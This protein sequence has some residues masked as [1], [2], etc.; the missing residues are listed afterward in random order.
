MLS[1]TSGFSNKQQIQMLYA[2]GSYCPRELYDEMQVKAQKGESVKFLKSNTHLEKLIDLQKHRFQN[3]ISPKVFLFNMIKEMSTFIEEQLK[4][5]K[6]VFNF[7]FMPPGHFTGVRVE[8][9]NNTLH[10]FHSDCLSHTPYDIC[11][12]LIKVMDLVNKDLNLSL[13]F[14][15]SVLNEDRQL[16][17]GFDCAIF[18][19]RD[20]IILE[21]ENISVTKLP[22]KEKIEEICSDLLINQIPLNAMS[23]KFLKTSQMGHS[24][25][26]MTVS[27]DLEEPQTSGSGWSIQVIEPKI[28]RT[29]KVNAY[30]YYLNIKYLAGL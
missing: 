1:S 2:P 24:Q 25:K 3:P 13:E 23:K 4:Q 30:T 17:N 29:D 5:D 20:L 10:F 28:V 21:K 16:K 27:V 9:K 6:T 14:E 12:T 15:V 11:E 19:L 26:T 7:I 18:A 22:V 8:R